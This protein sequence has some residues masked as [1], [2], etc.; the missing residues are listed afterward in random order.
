MNLR[1][2][3]PSGFYARSAV[4]LSLVLG[5]MLFAFLAL[6][7]P[8]LSDDFE[9]ALER[10][11]EV[12]AETLAAAS[13]H[14]VS[15]LD[16]NRVEALLT[17]AARTPGVE[18]IRIRSRDGTAVRRAYRVGKSLTVDAT[19]GRETR[20]GDIVRRLDM[21]GRTSS[22]GD[23][24]LILAE[25]RF[26]ASR[27]RIW[28]EGML[29][30]A[31]VL[32]IGML[33][34]EF[35]LKPA[36]RAMRELTDY[37]KALEAGQGGT[38]ISESGVREFEILAGAMRRAAAELTERS[39]VARAAS[40]RL[41]TAIEALDEGFVIYDRDDRL[42]MC[43][44][45]YR[46][47]YRLT[48]DLIVPGVSFET[49]IREG[50]RRGQYPDARGR[51]GAWVA[52]RLAT[53]RSANSVIE[54][55]LDDGRCLRISERRTPDGGVVGFRFDITELNE[56][57]AK[58][59][60][61]NRAKS[62]F[63]ANMSHEVRTPLAGIIGMIDLVQQTRLTE[64]QRG[65]VALAGSAASSLLEIVNDI[66]DISKIESVGVDLIEVPFTLEQ[67]L[68]DTLRTLRLRAES[69]QIEFQYHDE[70]ELDLDLVGDPGRLRQIVLNLVGN[71][72]KFTENGTI[73]IT[74]RVIERAEARAVVL[75]SVRD[76]GIGIAPEQH[77]R[78]FQPFAQADGST[79]RTYGGTGLG[80]AICKRLIDAMNGL[81]WLE[82]EPGKGSEFCFTV[83]YG[84][85]RRFE[86]VVEV[87]SVP[88]AT[89]LQRSLRILV[90]EDHNINRLIAN[91]LLSKHGHDVLEAET[92]FE[93]LALIEQEQLDLVLMDLQLPG[94]SGFE[95]VA[96][97]R[98]MSLPVRDLP[99]I[100]LTANALS[101]D[102]EQCLASGM[103]GYVSKPFKSATLLEEIGKVMAARPSPSLPGK[104]ASRF[105]RVLDT[106]END[107]ALF[108]EIA[109]LAE[110]IFDDT[111]VRLAELAR[112]GDFTTIA[113][114]A[115][116]LQ[117]NW[118]VYAVDGA[119]P[120][121]ERLKAAAQ[122]MDAAVTGEL[123]AQLDTRL[124]ETAAELR[125]WINQYEKE[126]M[127]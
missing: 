37:A 6:L 72:I 76:S 26:A 19:P 48:A 96:R 27:G 84:L 123:V 73:V 103:Q 108:A 112:A 13:V 54:Q 110:R 88:T 78:V 116:K 126:A 79:S 67:A 29:V 58:A 111:A 17:S 61:A 124:R 62:E 60:R 90:V 40:E 36:A 89:N 102:R 35:Q 53:H 28:R 8:Q 16:M 95:A 64:E 127:T 30:L 92:A 21:E 55:H 68:G 31:I 46:E 91:R 118:P 38:V 69:K 24:R 45:R 94:M 49:L 2:I 44:Q 120:L 82:S 5:V 57:R 121:P 32:G 22:I 98:S 63:L 3:L 101:G 97:L 51:I 33:V 81:I 41:T 39:E 80:L 7:V 109:A 122:K 115:H 20:S 113:A 100:A 1:R 11:A 56:A 106:L 77:D 43:N 50:A 4:I 10:D 86:P 59:E 75:F 71:A 74:A 93:A 99:V 52:E 12:L 70:T 66:L 104:P 65:F 47:Y 25:D 14:L 114:E 9:S 23:V 42:V 119:G 125:I 15:D 105:A 83:P 107:P 87:N 18:E 34:L 85:A 117:S